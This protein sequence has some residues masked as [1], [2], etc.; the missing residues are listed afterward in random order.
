V[1]ETMFASAVRLA[2]EVEGAYARSDEPFTDLAREPEVAKRMWKL[3]KDLPADD[4][5]RFYLMAPA[6]ET[7][8]AFAAWVTAP[9][10]R[11]R[12]V[13][14]GFQPLIDRL[15]TLPERAARAAEGQR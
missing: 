10:R 15:A 1:V 4:P 7:K 13:W 6:H 5:A 8:E 9:E 2:A 14:A 3:D 12:Q 11:T